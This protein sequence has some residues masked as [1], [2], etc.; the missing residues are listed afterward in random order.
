[1]SLS[2][3]G[4]KDFHLEIWNAVA[5]PASLPKPVIARLSALLSEIAR[6]PEVRQRL[7]QQGWQVAGGSS[8]ALARR[9]AADTT[10][11]GKIIAERGIKIE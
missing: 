1:P 4:V 6:S 3:A 5:G 10:A 2:E 9:I 11:M 8:E 7:Y